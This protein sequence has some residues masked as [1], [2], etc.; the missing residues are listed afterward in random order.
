MRR[1]LDETLLS[2]SIKCV[3]ILERIHREGFGA[4]DGRQFRALIHKNLGLY[5]ALTAHA[6]FDHDMDHAVILIPDIDPRRQAEVENI[7]KK[8]CFSKKYAA[9]INQKK[10]S[11]MVKVLWSDN[12]PELDAYWGVQLKA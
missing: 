3:E 1:K 11:V 9:E 10:R 12:S 5:V 2:D 6:M 7:F 8:I 4:Y